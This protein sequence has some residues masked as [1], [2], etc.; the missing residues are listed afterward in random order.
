MGMECNVCNGMECN[1]C[2]GMEVCIMGLS[3]MGW[4]VM[5]VMGMECNVCIGI[6]M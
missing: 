1:V 4:N 6:G 2:N 5:Y 3:C